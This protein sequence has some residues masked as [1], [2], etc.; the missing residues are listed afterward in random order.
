MS[1]TA[2]TPYKT[3]KTKGQCVRRGGAMDSSEQTV[4]SSAVSWMS[5]AMATKWHRPADCF[6]REPETRG[7]PSPTVVQARHRHDEC[8]RWCRAKTPPG[9]EVRRTLEVVGKVRRSQAVEAAVNENC[10]FVVD[11]LTHPQPVQLTKKRRHVISHC[12]CHCCNC[13]FIDVRFTLLL[14]KNV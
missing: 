14:A 7:L 3:K 8:A 9:V 11:P 4:L 12:K 10:Q 13:T 6:T 1:K 2:R 5:T